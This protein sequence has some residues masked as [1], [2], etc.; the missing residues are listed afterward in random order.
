VV[1]RRFLVA[2]GAAVAALAI[3][4]GGAVAATPNAATMTLQTGDIAGAKQR[5]SASVNEDGYLAA[6]DREFEVLRPFG[7]G[8]IVYV[9]NEV[10]VAASPSTPMRDLAAA[11]R[12]IRTKAGRAAIV[13]ELAKAAHLRAKD[14]AIGKLRAAPG[15]DE[16]VELPMSLKTYA[17]RL[18]ANVAFLRL[19]RVFVVITE[20]GVRPI[21]RA[22]TA[23][24][25]ALVAGHVK[26]ALTPL[27]VSPPTITGTPQQGQTLTASPGTW[28][29]DDVTL[30]YQ[31][32]H[33]DAAGANCTDIAGANQATYLVTAADVGFTIR[34]NVTATDRFGAPLAS[35]AP[36]APAT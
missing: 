3:L 20:V 1:R 27:N 23:R 4:A 22:D 2:G 14:V 25:A 21:A 26:G 16:G 9:E 34:A 28:N 35:S 12:G 11:A 13:A 7:I 18:Y 5:H 17:G 32:Q 6:Y 8:R 19:D 30:G 31:W 10:A 33:C 29:V 36:T 24:V 15:M